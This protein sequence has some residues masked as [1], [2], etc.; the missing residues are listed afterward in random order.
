MHI[1]DPQQFLSILDKDT[2]SSIEDRFGEIERFLGPGDKFKFT[3]DRS[4]RCCRNRTDNSI[5]LSPHDSY[6]LQQNLELGSADFTELYAQRVL[7]ADS[8][9][10]MLLLRFQR[11][12]HRENKCP[13][14]ES[15]GCTVYQDR[16]LVCRMYPVGRMV[17]RDMKSYFFLT[18]AAEYCKL[19][20]GKEY[21]I[22]QWLEETGSEPYCNWNDRFSSLYMEMDYEK[23]RALP[24][25][26]KATLGRFLYEFD[27]LENVLAD[28]PV[29]SRYLA[30]RDGRLHASYHA[31]KTLIE[32][33]MA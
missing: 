21:T 8:H 3:C 15:S 13:F 25:R 9:L 2:Y 11:S 20:R 18:K 33:M 14:L 17:D 12:G 23:F 19:G 29:V 28:D 4:G 5:I 1:C 22:E 7:G 16:P 30:K 24:R 27:Q 31:A 10:P 26:Y 32:R 6:R